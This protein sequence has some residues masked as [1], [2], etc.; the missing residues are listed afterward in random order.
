MA[1]TPIEP[2]LEFSFGWCALELTAGDKRIRVR[3][4][5]L[6]N[7][8]NDLLD[9][10]V[11]L[12]RGSRSQ[13]VIWGGEGSGWFIDASLDHAGGLGLVVHEMADDRWLRPG[14]AWRPIRG[15]VV[16]DAYGD[17]AQFAVSI[18][19]QVRAVRAR[20]TDPTGYM[21]HWGWSFPQSKFDLLQDLTSPLGYK[22]RS[23][24]DGERV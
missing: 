19:H 3:A 4:S 16:F 22:P 14:D 12:L 7:A 9:A 20:Y 15:P 21:P 5:T 6:S 23:L 13:S 1:V 10:V 2:V 8:F 11:C 17:F 18:A 24:D